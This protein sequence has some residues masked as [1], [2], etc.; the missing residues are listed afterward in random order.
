MRD[1]SFKYISSQF[2]GFHHLGSR[3]VIL[4][5]FK[6]DDNLK[7]DSNIETTDKKKWLLM[8]TMITK[9]TA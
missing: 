3:P 4:I 6:T 2:L 1:I 8:K 5:G 7:N 9:E